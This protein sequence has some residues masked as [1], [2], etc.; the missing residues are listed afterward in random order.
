MQI[1]KTRAVSGRKNPCSR[2][3]SVWLYRRSFGWAARWRSNR[4]ACLEEMMRIWRTLRWICINSA[5]V[6]KNGRERLLLY[7]CPQNLRTSSAS[8]Q[9]FRGQPNLGWVH[10]YTPEEGHSPLPRATLSFSLVS[11]PAMGRI[12]SLAGERRDEGIES[13]PRGKKMRSKNCRAA[14]GPILKLRSTECWGKWTRVR[15]PFRSLQKR[16]SRGAE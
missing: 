6:R 7:F 12:S 4:C 15:G 13:V 8:S 5:L 14:R 10:P 9:S 3:G 2:I 11:S 1:Y 16:Q